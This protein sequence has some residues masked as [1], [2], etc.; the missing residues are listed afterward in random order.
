MQSDDFST[1]NRAAPVEN[2]LDGCDGGCG[3]RP[4]TFDFDFT[5]SLAVRSICSAGD[6]IKASKCRNVIEVDK[7]SFSA[8]PAQ[9][10]I[11]K[12][13][14]QTVFV[15]FDNQYSEVGEGIWGLVLDSFLHHINKYYVYASCFRV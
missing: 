2:P 8:T 3:D 11:A 5:C 13:K 12:L 10:A 7:Q 15:F 6:S 14:L 4:V 1:F 9:L